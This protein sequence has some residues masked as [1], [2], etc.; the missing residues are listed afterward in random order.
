[1]EASIT[2]LQSRFIEAFVIT[3]VDKNMMN[4]SLVAVFDDWNE[5]QQE[6]QFISVFPY[7]Y[8][9]LPKTLIS[10]YS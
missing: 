7:K 2:D 8:M 10:I 9:V 1:M 6:Q 4:N 3:H 5:L